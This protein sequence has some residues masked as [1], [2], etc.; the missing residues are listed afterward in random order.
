MKRDRS[1]NKSNEKKQRET[2][3]GTKEWLDGVLPFVRKK[4]ER[5]FITALFFFFF[6]FLFWQKW[7]R[8]RLNSETKQIDRR[9]DPTRVYVFFLV[10]ARKGNVKLFLTLDAHSL[11]ADTAADDREAQKW[12]EC[13]WIQPQRA[14]TNDNDNNNELTFS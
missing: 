4:N 11:L 12:Q 8:K 9:E 6:F 14:T 1:L 10:D 13:A 5:M 7:R 2:I 3:T